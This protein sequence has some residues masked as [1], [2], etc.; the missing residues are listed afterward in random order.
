M[1]L[2]DAVRKHAEGH[3]AKHKA[4]VLVY[5]NNPAGIGE[6]PDIIEAIEGELMEMAKYQDQL[7]M[8]D[9]YFANEEQTQYTLFS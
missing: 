1:M 3:I 8:L 5:L 4:N 9:K 6:H 7:E 2:L